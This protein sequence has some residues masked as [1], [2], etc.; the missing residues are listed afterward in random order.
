MSG[1]ILGIYEDSPIDIGKIQVFFFNDQEYPQW[2]EPK[3][4]G[5]KGERVST[6][7]MY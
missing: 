4:F 5:K 3:I 6:N 2:L 1:F 7:H